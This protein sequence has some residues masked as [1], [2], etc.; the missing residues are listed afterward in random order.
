MQTAISQL[1]TKAQIEAPAGSHCH[2]R[3]S[4]IRD[5]RLSFC[6]C[7]CQ[8]E[9]GSGDDDE[10]FKYILSFWHR[11]IANCNSGGWLILI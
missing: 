7:H 9:A 10:D 4:A 1:A 8:T 6:F 2:Y 11:A 3:R 5:Q